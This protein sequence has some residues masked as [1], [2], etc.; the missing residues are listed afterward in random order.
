MGIQNDFKIFPTHFRRNILNLLVPL[1]AQKR[2]N[3]L[4]LG[5]AMMMLLNLYLGG[6]R[7][8]GSS[9]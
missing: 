3:R 6:M 2:N 8:H 4:D 1:I 5:H 7:Q 9:V